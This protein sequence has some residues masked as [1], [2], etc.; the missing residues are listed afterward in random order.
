MAK[1]FT[2]PEP[3]MAETETASSEDDY[4]L[5]EPKRLMAAE[6]NP[7]QRDLI[8]EAEEKCDALKAELIRVKRKLADLESDIEAL[9][10]QHRMEIEAISQ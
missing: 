9:Q 4:E 2:E 10:Q 1:S 5:E 7:G 6:D 3:E 8:S